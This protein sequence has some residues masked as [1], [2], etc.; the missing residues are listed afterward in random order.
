MYIDVIYAV[1]VKQNLQGQ[2]FSECLG[3]LIQ[4]DPHMQHLGVAID[5]FI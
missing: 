4:C 5:R 1:M 3:F 2:M